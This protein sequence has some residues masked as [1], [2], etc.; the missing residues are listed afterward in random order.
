VGAARKTSVFA[1]ACLAAGLAAAA[2]WPALWAR[3]LLRNLTGL[4]ADFARARWVWPPALELQDFTAEHP[5]ARFLARTARLSSRGAGFEAVFADVRIEPAAS[6]FNPLVFDRGR[7]LLGKGPRGRRVELREWRSASLDLEGEAVL[8][9]EGAAESFALE[10]R[11]DPAFFRA[12]VQEEFTSYA[13]PDR[14]ASFAIRC[15]D[16]SLTVELNGKTLFRSTWILR[17]K[18]E[19]PPGGASRPAEAPVLQ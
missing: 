19:A 5:R 9:P 10:G 8:R 17:A 6:W 18:G 7:L 3:P 2:V 12:Y 11:A 1:A 15:A 13:D 4:P 16:A 14:W